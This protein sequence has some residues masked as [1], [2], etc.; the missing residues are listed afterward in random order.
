MR[1]TLS[2]VAWK[3]ALHILVIG[4]LRNHHVRVCFSVSPRPTK[5][6]KNVTYESQHWYSVH[7]SLMKHLNRRKE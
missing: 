1:A 7:A 6:V 2:G 3:N 5:L 4:T